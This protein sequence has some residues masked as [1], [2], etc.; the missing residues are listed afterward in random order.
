MSTKVM[1]KSD[2]MFPMSKSSK[3]FHQDPVTRSYLILHLSVILWSF[4]AILGDLI[5]L[6][7]TV[8]VW[9][10]VAL[11]TV[12]MLFYPQ[13]VRYIPKIGLRQCAIFIGIGVLVAIHWLCFYGAIKLANASVALI[14]LSTA[15]LFTSFIEPMIARKSLSWVDV[16]FGLLVIPGIFLTTQGLSEGMVVGFWLGI[17]SAFLAALFAVLNKL[18]IDKAAPSVITTIEMGGAW[19][20]ITLGLLLFGNQYDLGTFWPSPQDWYYLL[21]LCILCTIVPFI[22]HLKV[23]EHLTAFASNLVINLEPVYG[24][25]LAML[26]LSDHQELTPVFYLG[27]VLIFLVVIIY[28]IVKRRTS[29]GSLG[30]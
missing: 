6:S 24:I 28:P 25:F 17:I 1:R 16:I 11:T 4:T 23:Y 15:T 29:R 5:M 30:T 12:F 18:H 10:R 13:V 7:A 22:L 9:W 14:C 3:L 27:V 2:I 8:L 19:I 21:V 20:F 26:I